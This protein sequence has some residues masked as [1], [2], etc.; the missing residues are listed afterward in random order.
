M[1]NLG[2]QTIY[3][4]LNCRQDTCCERAF[5]PNREDLAAFGP[6]RIP[7]FSLESQTPLYKFSIVAFSISYEV[8]Y[9][10]LAR[11]LQLARIT[12]LTCQ[13]EEKEPLIVVGGVA[14]FM[15]PEPIAEL[16]DVCII[17][18]E[19]INEFMDSYQDLAHR[20][21]EEQLLQLARLPGVYVPRYYSVLYQ[22][23]GEIKEIR[24]TANV[25]AVI[26]RRWIKDINSYP[27]VS[28]ILTTKTE[29]KNT[30]LIELARG[31][32]YRCRFCLV[33]HIYQPRR[34]MCYEVIKN[35]VLA[36]ATAGGRVGLVAATVCSY[37]WLEALC[38]L[39]ISNGI[40]ATFSSLRLM[41]SNLSPR[42]NCY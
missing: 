28:H 17:G 4:L 39:L 37:P 16:V 27:A 30:T 14:V 3:Y 10:H 15:N 31:C 40:A 6:G 8:D 2:F 12:P 25:P 36:A 38:R 35:E 26:A 18:E 41:T 19:I 1:S 32:P 29:F 7:L 11:L 42:C 20:S 22:P 5:L 33:S 13:R 9:L 24:P 23:T 21:K 34:A